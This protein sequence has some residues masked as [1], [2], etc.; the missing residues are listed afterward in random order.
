MEQASGTFDVLVVGGGPAG[1]ALGLRLAQLGFTVC[2]AECERFP[3]RHVGE[4]LP[5]AI[6]GTLDQL[7]LRGRLESAGLLQPYRAIVRWGDDQ[8]AM[9]R[10]MA[11]A[12]LQVDR[13]VFDAILLD[14]TRQAGVRVLQPA[15]V[16]DL[17]SSRHDVWTATV[18]TPQ[19]CGRIAA[20]IVALA[21]GRRGAF[22][23]KRWRLS[24]PTVALH[25]YLRNSF[26][27]D[28]DSRI[29]AIDEGWLWAAALP[30]CTVSVAAFIDP[31]NRSLREFRSLDRVLGLLLRKSTLLRDCAQAIPLAPVRA[32]DA[33][34]S[35]VSPAAADNFI[36]VG[37]ASFSVDPL[38]SQGVLH[39]IVS[40]I[41]AAAVI[42]TMLRRPA[43]SKAAQGFFTERQ[44]EVV[45]RDRAIGLAH[46]QAQALVT[47]TPF[48]LK[49]GCGAQVEDAAR[50]GEPPRALS[51]DTPLQLASD[52]ALRARPVLIGDFVESKIALEHAH[53]DRPVAFVRDVPIDKLLA[54]VRIGATA[55]EVL[56]Y[57]RKLLPERTAIGFLN[58]LWARSVITQPPEMAHPRRR[59]VDRDKRTIT[60]PRCEPTANAPWRH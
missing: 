27:A 59:G 47:P 43:D 29:E 18:R 10:S 3:R 50:R 1:A 26:W 13:G 24:P 51:L 7:G 11:A 54:A 25:G 37:D 4:S 44:N 46:Y 39:A 14:A 58:L 40:G 41:R 22:A 28:D 12:G 55:G 49:R 17:A 20:K 34:I 2:L 42:N 6:L 56:Q 57:W 32:C 45:E 33:A 35:V 15:T 16:V 19:G 23:G 36:R 9:Y 5:L 21:G 48:W 31:D 38:S 60:E 52:I 53:L 8:A 30:D